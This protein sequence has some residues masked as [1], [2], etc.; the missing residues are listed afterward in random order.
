MIQRLYRDTTP[1]GQASLSCHD[2]K[3]CIVTLTPN[4]AARALLAVSWPSLAVSWDVLWPSR[5]YRGLS[6]A[7]KPASPALCHDTN[8]CTFFF[9]FFFSSFFFFY[10][11]HY[12]T[13]EKN[14]FTSFFFHLILDYLLKISQ[15]PK[16]LFSPMLLTKHTNHTTQSHIT[17]YS[18]K[19]TRNVCSNPCPSSP[20]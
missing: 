5:P 12:K 6:P 15:P 8:C 10:F 14:F 7:P 11:T 3:L 4:Q 20:R 2:T 19:C 9:L 17:L 13:L 1:S 18:S 16:V